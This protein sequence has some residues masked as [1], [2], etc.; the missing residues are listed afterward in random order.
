VL[1][2]LP[3]LSDGSPSTDDHYA[4][5]PFSDGC[6]ETGFHQPRSPL[7]FFFCLL[8]I[9]LIGSLV[10]G[11]FARPFSLGTYPPLRYPGFFL[12]LSTFKLSIAIS[13]GSCLLAV[14]VV[15]F[16]LTMTM[17]ASWTLANPPFSDEFD[18]PTFAFLSKPERGRFCPPPPPA[19]SFF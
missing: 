7:H 10:G 12:P 5:F 8:P 4:F 17:N 14:E 16:S 18:F 3:V 1:K 6:G 15:F 11:F 9:G 2:E 19:V 13:S